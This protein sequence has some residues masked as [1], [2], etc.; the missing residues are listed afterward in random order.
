MTLFGRDSLITSWMALLVDPE[1]ALGVL[2]TLAR[3]QGQEGYPRNDEE[4]GRI[5][6]EM[7]FGDAAS[8][9]LGGGSVYYG[10]ADATP[11]FVMLLAELRRW[12]LAP[13]GVGQLLPHADRA[14]AWI[15]EFGDKDGDGYVEYRRLS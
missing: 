3:F 9:S 2:Q 12:G 11:L 13:E 5:L 10:S 4:P 14:L 15:D 6:H 8:L 7:R 1:P